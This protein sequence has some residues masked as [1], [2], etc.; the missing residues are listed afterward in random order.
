M[1][2]WFTNYLTN[3]QQFVEFENHRSLSQT[4]QCGVP[5]G[6]ILG[7]LLYLIHLIDISNSCGSHI[8]S[9]A[10]DTTIYLS[11]SDVAK[12]V[13]DANKNVNELFQWFCLMQ[14]KLNMLL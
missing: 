11:S 5:Q 13:E 10:D 8:L 6:S 1:N 9:F 14:V 7:P 3:R 2:E 4:I 12:L